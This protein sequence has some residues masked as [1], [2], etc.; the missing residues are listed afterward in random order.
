MTA[1]ETIAATIRTSTDASA[2]LGALFTAAS[3][4]F[5]TEVESFVVVCG[6]LLGA[7]SSLIV[8]VALESALIAAH[9]G[10]NRCAPNGRAFAAHSA[11]YY[12]L[13]RALVALETIEE[14]R[15]LAA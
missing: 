9:E 14:E 2:E 4:E 8:R 15:A 1:A 10:M 6:D 11:R 7:D 5:A 3:A 13:Y 12:P